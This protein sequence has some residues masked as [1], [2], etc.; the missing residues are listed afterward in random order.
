[1]LGKPKPEDLMEEDVVIVTQP[2]ADH[3]SVGATTAED[4]NASVQTHWTKK[5][6]LIV[7]FSF[8]HNSVFKLQ[9]LIEDLVCIYLRQ[10]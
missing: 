3:Q 5:F 2:K 1:M 8:K 7:H 9:L 10:W 6:S 4:K